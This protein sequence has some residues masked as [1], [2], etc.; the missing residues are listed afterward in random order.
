MSK[1]A[2]DILSSL[3]LMIEEKKVYKTVGD[4]LAVH[5]VK[6]KMSYMSI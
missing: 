4:K 6:N 1:V 3:S 5:F 2:D